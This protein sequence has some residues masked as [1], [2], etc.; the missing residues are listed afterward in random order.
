[1][2]FLLEMMEF[3]VHVLDLRAKPTAIVILRTTAELIAEL[4]ELRPQMAVFDAFVPTS[5]ILTHLRAHVI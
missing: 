3:S 1:M 5:A 2:Q 4:V